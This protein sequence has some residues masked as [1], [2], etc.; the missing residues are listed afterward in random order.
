MYP[1]NQVNVTL[2][3]DNKSARFENLLKP[4]VIHP[5]K[6]KHGIL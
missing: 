6:L 1:M 3:I 2:I 4:N 5:S